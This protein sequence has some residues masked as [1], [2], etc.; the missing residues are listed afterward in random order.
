KET[1]RKLPLLILAAILLGYSISIAAPNDM[2]VLSST[3]EEFHFVM[4][5]DGGLGKLNKFVG[6]DSL[7]YLSRAVQI[8]VPYGATARLAVASGTGTVS[9]SKSSLS[10][11]NQNR[12]VAAAPLARLSENWTMRRRQF[13]TVVVSPASGGSVFNNVEIKV[14]FE[15]ARA[16]TGTSPDDRIFERIF[17]NSIA[18]WQVCR[19]WTVAPRLP[20]KAASIA[21]PF[22]YAADWYKIE[23]NSNAIYA[24]SFNDLTAAGSLLQSIPAADL[25]LYYG[26][27]K[28]VDPLLQNPRPTFDQIAIEIEDNNSNGSFDAGDRILFYGESVNRWEYDSAGG[29]YVKNTYVD[30]NVYWLAVSSSIPETELRI[31]TVDVTPDGTA[32]DTM[33]SYRRYLRVEQDNLLRRFSDGA[34]DDY[35]NWYWAVGDSLTLFVS[36][37]DR[38]AGQTANIFLGGRTYD[39]TGF[40]DAVGFMDLIV[41]GQAAASKLCDQFSCSYQAN[42]LVAG[43][44][45]FELTLWG[46][47]I[48]DPYFDYLEIDYEAFLTPSGNKIDAFIGSYNGRVRIDIIDNF[49]SQ[50][51]LYNLDNPGQPIKLTGFQRQNGLLSFEANLAAGSANRFFASGSGE[52]RQPLS[53]T[54]STAADLYVSGSQTDMIIITTAGLAAALSGYVGYRSAQGHS[55]KIVRVSDIMDNFAFGLYDPTAIRDYLKYAYENYPSPAPAHV[56]FVGDANYDFIDRLG[57]GVVNFV[58]AYLL[59][60]DKTLSDDNYVYFGEYGLIDSDTTY[61]TTFVSRDRGFDMIP[62]RWPVRTSSEIASITAKMIAY[63]SPQSFGSWRT[64]I[65]L[66]ADDEFG[67][68]NNETFHVTQT[69]KL[70]NEHVPNYINNEKIYLWDYPLLNGAK[71]E[72]NDAI[73]NS[74]NQGTLVLNYV[75]HGNPDLWAHEHILSRT[76]DLPRM[77]NY[78]RLPLVFTASCAI[79]FFDDPKREGMAEDFIAMQAGAISV[80]SAT[81]LVYSSDNAAFN[82]QVFDFMLYDDSLTMSEAVYSAKVLRQYATVNPPS[83][84]L[85]DR[86]Y[87]YFGDPFLRLAI[88]TNDITVDSTLDSLEA[89]RPVRITGRVVDAGGNLITSD[90]QLTI[91]VFDS[92]RDKTFRLVNSSGNVIQTIP[93]KTAG[94]TIFRGTA[95]ITAGNYDF[96]FIPPLDIGY[97]GSG[98]KV[99][100]YAVLGGIDAVGIIDSIAVATTVANSTD[101]AGP[102][103]SLSFSGKQFMPSGNLVSPGDILEIELSDPSGIN[104]AGG[105]GHGIS[106][107]FDGEAASAI[108]LTSLFNF[109]QDD[110]TTGRLSYALDQ[111]E[112]GQ[113]SI[114]IKAWDNA[115]NSSSVSFTVDMVNSSFLAIQQLLNYPNPMIDKTIFSYSLTQTVEKLTLEIFTL[116]GRKINSF[117]RFALAAAYYDDI[118]WDG[119]DAYGDRVATGVYIFKATAQP[120]IGDAVEEFGK[121]VVINQ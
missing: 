8:G 35:Y 31:S 44:N 24:L 59:S 28:H 74:V 32:I 96:G 49:T 82:R 88:P 93:Y 50:P 48:A 10:L 55:I 69:E 113:H 62:S 84:V 38:V 67:T 86:N 30:R 117:Q 87:M 15:G 71:P 20:A 1:F 27:G 91:T 103:I 66:V 63:E 72:V 21:A 34:P 94:P 106:I 56:L 102:D 52:I 18:N 11:S 115:N 108:N 4:H 121:I 29:S 53:F 81:R 99:S 89:L 83:P 109:D 36:T 25:F 77:T 80:I 107:E 5:F 51:V 2:T 101:S 41:N 112:P 7:L 114:K 26:G 46:A 75:G 110:F 64:N 70:G 73:V 16:E 22:S 54:K 17:S 65:T 33:N 61:D 105:L 104:L 78:D 97:G 111:I 95:S 13:V 90:G 79:G 14:V 37:S 119:R 12:I 6:E 116:S 57:T 3:S 120:T 58:P 40:M 76:S 45:R 47:I 68:F 39:T 9:I 85:N 118:V 43:F 60:F 42:N 23:I 98:A 100:M 19:N 92:E